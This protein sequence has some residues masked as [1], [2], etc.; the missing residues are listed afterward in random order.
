[1]QKNL[2]HVWSVGYLHFRSQVLDRD[3]TEIIF[4]CKISSNFKRMKKILKF[5]KFVRGHLILFQFYKTT[6]KQWN[7]SIYM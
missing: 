1:M 2:N 6:E 3:G 4:N 5:I 7:V